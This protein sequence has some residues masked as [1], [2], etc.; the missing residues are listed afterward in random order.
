MAWDLSSPIS[1]CS[2]YCP[3]SRHRQCHELTL[4]APPRR[5]SN[6][7]FPVNRPCPKLRQDPLSL[8]LAPSKHPS[9]PVYLPLPKSRSLYFSLCF[10]V[11]FRGSPVS[12][13]CASSLPFPIPAHHALSCAIDHGFPAPN[14]LHQRATRE[15]HMRARE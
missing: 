4:G 2:L 3:C 14:R 13:Q 7:P 9:F 10:P 1:T 12:K 8:L 5:H 6:Y 15:E 11:D